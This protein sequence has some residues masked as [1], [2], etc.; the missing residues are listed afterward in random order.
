MCVQVF[1]FLL[2]NFEYIILDEAQTRF[3]VA[4]SIYMGLISK[5]RQ[6]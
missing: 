5:G 1:G 4:L 3:Q 2:L 6:N